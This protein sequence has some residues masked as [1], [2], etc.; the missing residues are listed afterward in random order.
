MAGEVVTEAVKDFL[1]EGD[2]ELVVEWVDGLGEAGGAVVVDV[3][4]FEVVGEGIEDG[5]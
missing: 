3:L 2:F 5:A 1:G 4:V